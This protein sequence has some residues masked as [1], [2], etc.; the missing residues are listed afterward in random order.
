MNRRAMFEID[1]GGKPKQ[2]ETMPSLPHTPWWLTVVTGLC[3][4]LVMPAMICA[5][6]EKLATK[7]AKAGDPTEAPAGPV[8]RL[9]PYTVMDEPPKLCFDIALEVWGDA[10]TGK[11]TS[12]Y[13]T[14]VKP[15][16]HAEELG[17]VPRTRIDRIDGIPVEDLTPS[18]RK[19]TVLNRTFINRKFGA[20][21]TL[22]VVVP[23]GLESKTV[24]IIEKPN[25]DFRFRDRTLSVSPR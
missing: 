14:K 8:I 17:L 10:N 2:T 9:D 1:S 5:A 19:G 6:Q 25:L 3:A 22:E 24:T 11:V 13:I 18:F 20:R 7:S 16:S 23:G 12:L 21:V 15:L 4:L